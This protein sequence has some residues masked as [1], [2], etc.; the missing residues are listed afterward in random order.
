MKTALILLA[1]FLFCSAISA[2]PKDK[3]APLRHVVMFKFKDTA[4]KEQIAAI[5]KGFS[6]LPKK[7]E[8][9]TGYEWGTNVS[10]ENKAQGF[11]HCFIVSF[12]NQKGLD[13]YT[14][15]AAH[16]AFVKE[17][18]PILDKVL[19]LDFIAQS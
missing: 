4:T 12:K 13:V 14:P 16:Q 9:I 3:V 7:I 10:K 6:A 1:S 11:T 8:T 5:E 17:L 15:H 19:V 18:L 2:E